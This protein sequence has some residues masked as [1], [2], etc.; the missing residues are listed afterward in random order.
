MSF[1]LYPNLSHDLKE[2]FTTIIANLELLIDAKNY[3]HDYDVL[4]MLRKIFAQCLSFEEFITY[5]LENI[6]SEKE[7]IMNENESKYDILII[8]DNIET[9]NFL[10]RYF[11]NLGYSCKEARTGKKGLEILEESKPSIIFLDIILPDISGYDIVESVRSNIDNKD[12]Q[13]IFLTAV[14]NT[15]AMKKKEE[16]GV[17][18]LISKPFSLKDFEII[19]EI[20]KRNKKL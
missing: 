17:N 19:D 9:L 8:E 4:N 5:T 2:Q 10:T 14:P 3:S 12:I 15:E 7:M 6:K 1:N 18:G 13:I 20:L 16:L 11:K